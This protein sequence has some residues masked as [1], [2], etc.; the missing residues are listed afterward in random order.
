[1]ARREHIER[2]L[3]GPEVH[4]H[5]GTDLVATFRVWTWPST[6]ELRRGSKYA[7]A[8]REWLRSVDVLVPT[9]ALRV[10][11]W[12]GMRGVQGLAVC[13]RRDVRSSCAR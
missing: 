4:V 5:E 12:P 1:M 2:A 3:H 7:R 10:Q 11:H 9:S 13:G 8:M 6:S